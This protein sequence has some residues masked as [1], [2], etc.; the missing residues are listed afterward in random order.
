M[1]QTTTV[2]SYALQCLRQA[3]MCFWSRMTGGLIKYVNQMLDTGTLTH[4]LL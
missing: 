3:A 1:R 2:S 4:T